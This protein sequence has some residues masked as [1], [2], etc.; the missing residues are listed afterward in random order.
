MA[1]WLVRLHEAV[2]NDRVPSVGNHN[3]LEQFG[4]GV[5]RIPAVRFEIEQKIHLIRRLG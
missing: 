4:G 5:S 3:L 1:S 2:K